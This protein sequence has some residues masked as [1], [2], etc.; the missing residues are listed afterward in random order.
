MPKQRLNSESK[1]LA[2]DVGATKTN[3]AL[4]ETRASLREPSKSRTFQNEDYASFY[5][6]FAEYLEDVDDKVHGLSLGVAGPVR[7]GRVQMTNLPWAIEGQ[8]I[9]NDFGIGKVWLLNDLK[10]TAQAIPLM[11]ADELHLLN[12]GRPDPEGTIAVIAPGT[13]LGEAYLTVKNGEYSAHASEGG[14]SD[15]A[16]SNELQNE[17]LRY[18][19]QKFDQVSYERVCSGNGLPNIYRFLKYSGRAKEPDWLLQLLN[20]TDDPTAVIVDT[21]LDEEKSCEIC[22]MT[23]QI[24]VEILGSEAGNLALKLGATGGVYLAG[25]IPPRILPALEKGNFI[26]AFVAKDDYQNYLERIP[27]QVMLNQQAALLGAADYG[28]RKMQTE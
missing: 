4:F 26:A 6:L 28:L 13:G 22:K 24:F 11:R 20:Q 16:P 9:R 17:L 12:N 5:E 7:A 25:G 27:V 23:L 2:G 15:F 14:H 10:V 8:K 3:F 19:R 21:A 18:L 1:L